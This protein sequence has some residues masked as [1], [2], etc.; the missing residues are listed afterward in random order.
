MPK[1]RNKDSIQSLSQS[2]TKS[3][4]S[5]TEIETSEISNKNN[6]PPH[7]ILDEG[8]VTKEDQDLV[9]QSTYLS[10]HSFIYLIHFFYFILLIYFHLLILPTY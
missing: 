5:E 9:I 8:N 4:G 10:I 3:P 2:T 1:L 6:L 7:T